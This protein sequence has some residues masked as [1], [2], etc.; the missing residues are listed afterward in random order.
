MTLQEL[1]DA[2]RITPEEFDELTKQQEPVQ[3]E[4][5]TKEP[6]PEP[7]PKGAS[8]FED[9]VNDLNGGN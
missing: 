5:Q 7:K 9:Y 4:P 6:E 3:A 1:L 8:W 2:E